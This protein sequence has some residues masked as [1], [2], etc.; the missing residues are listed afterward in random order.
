[1]DWLTWG[2]LILIASV[3]ILDLVLISDAAYQI[4]YEKPS[5]IGLERAMFK[6][7][8]ATPPDCLRQGASKLLT[9]IAILLIQVPVFVIVSINALGGLAPTERW[10]DKAIA[11]AGMVCVGLGF[12]LAVSGA[13]VGRKVRFITLD[14][15]VNQP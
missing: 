11:L 8:P 14:R 2:A 3:V 9:Y 6:R 1:M 13:M 7:E 15:V 5:F 12:F 10:V 4:V